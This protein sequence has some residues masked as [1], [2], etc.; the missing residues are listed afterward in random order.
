MLLPL[1]LMS[2]PVSASAQVDEDEVHRADRERTE[3]LNRRAGSVLEDRND[4]NAHTLAR[5][6]EAREDYERKRA[7]W[8][9][10]VAACDRGDDRAC[11][12]R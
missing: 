8:R 6:R 11:D 1:M 2:L 9:R 3:Q 4:A 12:P 10:Q 5:Y 7:A